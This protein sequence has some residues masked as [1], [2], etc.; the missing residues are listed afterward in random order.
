MINRRS[1]LVVV[2][3]LIA[4]CA[5]EQEPLDRVQPDYFDSHFFIGKET[6]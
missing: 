4:G 1:W 2:P 3:L 5:I 6:M